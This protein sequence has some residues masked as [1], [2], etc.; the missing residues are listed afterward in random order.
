MHAFVQRNSESSVSDAK[1]SCMHLY[2][3][4]RN[5][6]SPMPFGI[7]RLRCQRNSES[8]ASLHEPMQAANLRNT[9]PPPNGL[10]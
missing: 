4:I 9:L 3:G 5:R 10:G 7:E 1:G 6:V 8:S 2:S